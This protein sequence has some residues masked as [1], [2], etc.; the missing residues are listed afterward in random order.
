MLNL[1]APFINLLDP[2]KPVFDARTWN[3]VIILVMGAILTPGKRSVTAALGVMGLRFEQQFAKYHQVLNRNVWSSLKCSQIMLRLLLSYLDQGSE[4]LVF[5][6]DETI[7]RRTGAK[8]KAR[9]IYRDPVRSSKSHF[10]KASGLR[11]MSMMWLAKIPWAERRWALPFL[12]ALCPSER[13]YEHAPR[14]HKKLTDW[15][16]QLIFQLRRCLPHR[17][18]VIV[19]DNSYAALDLLHACQS[20]ANPVTMITRLRLD[21]A[22]YDPAPP[23][24]GIGRPR[25]KGQ[26]LPTPQ[27]HLEASD[28][29]WHAVEVSWYDGQTRTMEMASQ[30]AV[31]FHYGKSAVP[32]R[33]VL[34][35]DPQ[36]KYETICLLC[37]DDDVLPQQIVDWFVLRWQIEVTFEESRRHLGVETQRQWSDLAIARTTPCLLALFSWITLVA[38]LFHQSDHPISPNS[39]AWYTKSLPTFSDALAVVR[40]ELWSNL[41]TFETSPVDADVSK[42]PRPLLH[43]LLDALCYAA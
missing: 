32:I 43:Y 9:G 37:T 20:L 26:R 35:R 33:W 30:T 21:A 14:Q 31:W 27:H 6:I 15:A 18:L 7:E 42:V 25:K 22:L 5:G 41:P 16:R 40:L 19:A 28:T 17:W 8:L 34:V 2:F 13:Y 4:P 1:P 29:A 3:K 39:T 36:G 38:H 23:Y 12:T 24:A 10:V 11:W